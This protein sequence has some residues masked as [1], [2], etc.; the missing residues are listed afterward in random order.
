MSRVVV[1]LGCASRNLCD[2][3]TELAREYRPD[4]IYG[5]DP[6]A[7]PS[8]TEADGVPVKVETKVAWVYDGTIPFL[9]DG[10]GSR[11]STYSDPVPC[12]DFVPWLKRLCGDYDEVFVKMDIEGAEYELIGRMLDADV[13]K[14]V[15]YLLVEWHGVH[16]ETESAALVERLR[17][18]FKQW[19]M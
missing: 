11:I 5:F 17:C 2:S 15:D 18:P 19:W 1:D 6:F 14:L 3:L 8:Q 12:F 16:W 9:E 4:I 10:T 7:D 13:D